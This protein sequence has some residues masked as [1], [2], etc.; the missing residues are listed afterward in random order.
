MW[1]STALLQPQPERQEEVPVLWK[2]SCL[3]TVPKQSHPSALSDYR[4]AALTSHIM[5]VLKRLLLAY[6]SKRGVAF[7]DPLQFAYGMLQQAHYS[8][9]KAGGTVR[10]IFFDSS[11]DFKTIQPV[12]LCKKQ[13]KIQVDASTTTRSHLAAT[14]SRGHIANSFPS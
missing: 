1:D 8:L 12:L 2:T 13:Q 4:P 7:Q 6:L 5:K 10:I 11:S 3:V 9:H 14:L